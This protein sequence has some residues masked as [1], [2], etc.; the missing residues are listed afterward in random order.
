MIRKLVK[1]MMGTEQNAKDIFQ[2]TLVVALGQSIKE[3]FDGKI[4]TYLYAIA[5][6]KC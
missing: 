6:N 5:Q 2:E 1:N 4:S 3:G